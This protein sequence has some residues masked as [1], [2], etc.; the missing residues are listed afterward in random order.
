MT[1]AQIAYWEEAMRRMVESPEWKKELATNFWRSEYLRSGD[2]RKNL[3]RDYVQ[4]RAFLADL[5]LAK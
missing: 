5:G 1:D 2:A 4:A 3:D